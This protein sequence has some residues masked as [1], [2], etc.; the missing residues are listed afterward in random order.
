MKMIVIVRLWEIIETTSISWSSAWCKA[1]SQPKLIVHTM[2][3][4]KVA[5][6]HEAGWDQPHKATGYPG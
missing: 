3:P 4:V 2:G 5:S 1:N 6:I